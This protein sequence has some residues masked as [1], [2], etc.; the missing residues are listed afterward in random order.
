MKCQDHN[1]NVIHNY[2]EQTKKPILNDEINL[3]TEQEQKKFVQDKIIS[4]PFR[5]NPT[6]CH[7]EL[8][9]KSKGQLGSIL[10]IG[11]TREVFHNTKNQILF[12]RATLDNIRYFKNEKG[13]PFCQRVLFRGSFMFVFF[14]SEDQLKLLTTIKPKQIFIDGYHKV[15][16]DFQQMVSVFGYSEENCEAFAIFHCL[17]NSKTEENYNV[18]FEEF[19]A[20]LKQYHPEFVFMPEICTVD[21]EK[22]LLNSIERIFPSSLISGLLLSF[23]SRSNKIFLITWFSF[24]HSFII[25]GIVLDP[26][27][28][29][30]C[31]Y[32]IDNNT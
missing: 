1:V 20:I 4:D 30:I 31:R 17:L 19:F 2:F 8:L 22:A 26:Y 5:T 18:M 6:A 12:P 9:S 15:P 11:K 28:L 32:S 21:F 23:P 27:S 3:Q 24:I 13:N 14:C 10:S 16:G 7:V 25:K 29:Y